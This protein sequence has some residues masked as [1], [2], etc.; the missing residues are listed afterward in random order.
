MLDVSELAVEARWNVLQGQRLGARTAALE[1]ELTPD[2]AEQLAQENSA[3]DVPL[4]V[5]TPYG[6]MDVE[7]EDG[8]GSAL[9]TYS[10][11]TEAERALVMSSLASAEDTAYLFV[12]DT[13]WPTAESFSESRTLLATKLDRVRQK[14]G[15][16]VRNRDLDGTFTDPPHRHVV[17][18]NEAIA[19]LVD[20]DVREHVAVIYVPLTRA[21]SATR[22][23]QELLEVH[24][25]LRYRR[26]TYGPLPED[27]RSL[28]KRDAEEEVGRLPQTFSGAQTTLPSSKA[29]VDAIWDIADEVAQDEG[30]RYFI[31]M[32][33]TL[34]RKAVNPEVPAPPL[35]LAVAAVGNV[36]DKN[37]HAEYVDFAQRSSSGSVIAVLNQR[38]DGELQCYSSTV[39]TTMLAE[40]MAVGFDGM[41]SP[42]T[43]A[44][45]YSTP[46]V[47]WLLAL[48]EAARDGTETDYLWAHMLKERLCG[49]RSSSVISGLW[50]DLHRLLSQ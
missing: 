42:D 50:L 19:P 20:M 2:Q 27:I 18:V 1:I 40:I 30:R 37:V 34:A 31:S 24:F 21:Q 38:R 3:L 10:F 47:A 4:E 9:Q 25:L 22:L 8:G 12:L 15:L 16:G 28:A 46:R 36:P 45:S 32:S 23:L 5:S 13:G 43:C 17:K 44:T 33:W 41:V 39:D 29:I 6:P 48:A 7:L 26:N 35:G 49:I 14:H 11:I